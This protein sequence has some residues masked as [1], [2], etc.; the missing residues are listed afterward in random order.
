[1]EAFLGGDVCLAA[2]PYHIHLTA[3]AVSCLSVSQGNH[4]S[5]V[6]LKGPGCFPRLGTWHVFLFF[7]TATVARKT[8]PLGADR[9]LYFQ[10]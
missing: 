4:E 1:M 2:Y 8:H 7:R 3:A 6:N 10:R 9:S 5:L